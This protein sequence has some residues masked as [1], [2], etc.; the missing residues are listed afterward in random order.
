MAGPAEVLVVAELTGTGE[1]TRAT[2]E[3]LT[4]ARVLGA[5][6]AVVLGVPGAAAGAAAELARFGAGR[7]LVGESAELDAALAGPRVDVLARLVADR[8][9]A[10]VVVPAS[11]EGREVAARLAVRTGSGFLTDVVGFAA[12]GS[13]TQL[14]F[15]GTTVVRARVTTGTP[16][17]AWRAASLTPV[18]APVD[19]VVE[20]VPV[21]LS[22]TAREARVVR[23]VAGPAAGRP[24]LTEAS[25]VVA[26]GRGV[27]TAAELAAVEELAD[28][29]GAAIGATRAAVD[30]GSCP[31]SCLVGQSGARV[32]PRLY[33]A[34]GISGAAQHWSGVR[35]AQTVVAVNSDPDAPVF[36][37]ADFGVV[38]DVAT[39]VPALTAQ[40]T[41][42]R[43]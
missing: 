25:V 1:P 22:V 24:A 31:P 12:D 23:R 20:Q 13:A 2:L 21:E 19:P 35:A 11:A 34:V 9:P 42:A 43:A 38:G 26:V 15:G 33:V 41:A 37:L 28:A 27:T 8:A 32:S 39:V 17:H 3:A 30:A 4:A 36:A 40:I 5:P 29:L 7:V 14:A 6:V 16:V 18:P 10:A